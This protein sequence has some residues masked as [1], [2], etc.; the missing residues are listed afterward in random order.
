VLALRDTGAVRLHYCGLG[1]CWSPTGHPGSVETGGRPDGAVFVAADVRYLPGGG[2]RAAAVVAADPAFP[3]LADDR[4][5]M[6]AGVAPYEPGR[7]YLRELPP[8][9]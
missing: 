1:A 3:R 6:V 4:I 2:A 5:A 8:L 7:F 9:R